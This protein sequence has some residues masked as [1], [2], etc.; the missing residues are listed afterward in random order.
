MA[1]T[2]VRHLPVFDRGRCLGVLVETDLIRCLTQG[3]SFGAGLTAVV[4]QLFRPTSQLPPTARVS[5]AARC[6]SADVSD[7]VLV[8]DHGRI[9]GIVTATDLV[10]LLARRHVPATP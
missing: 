8:T 4:W 3:P 10:H 1:T 5:D 2:G 9:L 6:I 7:A